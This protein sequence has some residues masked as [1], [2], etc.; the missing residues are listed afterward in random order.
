MSLSVGQ[1]EQ[2]KRMRAMTPP[3][4]WATIAARL[5][6]GSFKVKCAL[7]P[8]YQ[9]YQRERVRLRRVGKAM[10]DE[11]RERFKGLEKKNSVHFQRPDQFSVPREVLIERDYRRQLAP[12]SLT[13]AF[14]GDPLPGYA[15]LDKRGA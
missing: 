11:M 6:C 1:L 13:A 7:I 9:E 12:K 2:A 8:W 10:P 14:C 15:A 4:N 3:A 5:G